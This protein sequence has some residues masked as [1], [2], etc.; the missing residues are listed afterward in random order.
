MQEQEHE[1]KGG[2]VALLASPGMGHLIPLLELGKRLVKYHALQV[3][4][5]VVTTDTSISQ[6]Q[7]IQRSEIPHLLNIVVLPPVAN[8]SPVDPAAT[9]VEKIIVT[10]KESLAALRSAISEM[11]LRPTALIV[12]LFGTEAMAIADEFEM[13][14]YAFIA[15]NALFLAA[16]MYATVIDQKEL[17][18]HVKQQQPLKIPGCPPIRF[19]DTLESFRNL[20]DPISAGFSNVGIEMS[21]ADGILVNTWED[22]ESTTLRALKDANTLRPIVKAPVYPIGPLVRP[23]ERSILR[24]KVLDWLDMQPTESVIYVSFGSGGTISS[25]Q[26]IELAWGLETSQQRFIWVVR[27]PMENEVCEFYLTAGH[28]PDGTP[29]YLPDGFLTRNAKMG[30]VVPNWAPQAEILPHPS[31]GGFLT[32]CGWNSALESIANGVPMIA[33]PLYAEQKMNA[34][35]LTEELQVALRSKV[36]PSTGVVK[37]EEIGMMIRRIVVDKEGDEMRRKVKVLKRSA[38]KVYSKGGSSY[39]ALSQ[40]ANRVRSRP[41][42]TN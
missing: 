40:V 5:F 13:L 9:V 29:D 30:L 37:R 42:Y 6:S 20:D 21:N 38:E 32:H 18:E 8:S 2:H 33:W 17:D 23:G 3:T 28:G 15:S 16:T 14:K 22:L 12:D 41:K 10:M 4:V 25:E 36:L 24:N 1:R 26:M 11:K 34:A 31:V 39:N 7:L 35:M 19:E 27:P